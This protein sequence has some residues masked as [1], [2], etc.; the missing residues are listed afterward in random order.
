M[1]I[2]MKKLI[3]IALLIPMIVLAQ[4]KPGFPTCE[5]ELAYWQEIFF[6]TQDKLIEAQER[7]KRQRKIIRNL[8]WKLSLA[9]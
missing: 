6:N 5:D 7:S 8:R 2:L 9:D 1:E 3:L 4:A